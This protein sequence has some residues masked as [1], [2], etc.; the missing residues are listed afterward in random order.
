MKFTYPARI[1]K[2]EKGTWKAIFPDLECC[3]AEGDTVEETV[4]L[5]NEA[6]CDWIG[7]ELSEEDGQ[8]PPVTDVRDLVLEE[9]EIVRNICVNIRFTDGW[10]E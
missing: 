3:E 10:D 7:L 2:T 6:A 4:E 9:G 5:A 8:L 1:K